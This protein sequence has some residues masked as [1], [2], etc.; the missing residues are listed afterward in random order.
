DGAPEGPAGARPGLAAEHAM[1][2][3]GG[4]G[5]NYIPRQAAS[6][7]PG[8]RRW[9]AAAGTVTRLSV[10]ALSKVEQANVT[11]RAFP[12]MTS[13]EPVIPRPTSGAVGAGAIAAAPSR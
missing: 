10:E 8:R 13:T 7:R 2:E 4:E 6:A 12:E 3:V 1:V 9:P 11:S 5:E